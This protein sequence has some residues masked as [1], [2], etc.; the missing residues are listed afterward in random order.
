[1]I[2]RPVTNWSSERNARELAASNRSA[3][4]VVLPCCGVVVPGTCPLLPYDWECQAVKDGKNTVWRALVGWVAV[5]VST[6]ACC[7]WAFWWTNT[8]VDA[9]HAYM[10]CYNGQVRPRIK[11]SNLAYLGS[12]AVKDPP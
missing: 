11:K 7:F 2:S 4:L 3:L 8:E 5:A 12:R 9:D 6:F 10:V 1:M